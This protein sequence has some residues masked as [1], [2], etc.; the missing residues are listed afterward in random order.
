[1]SLIDNHKEAFIKAV[2]HFVTDIATLKTGR[3]NPAILDSISVDSYGAMS[4]INQVASVSVP[5]ARS[6]VIQPWDKG[7]LEGLEK[8]IRD[9][10]LGLSPVNEGDKIRI[11]IPQ[12]TEESRKDIVKTLHQKTEE[13]RIALRN[14]RDSV[15][16]EILEAEKNKEFG[17]DEKFTLMEELDKAVGS[18][19]T[20]IKDISDKKE[21]DIMKV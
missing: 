2:D 16:D 21:A 18:Y 13:A 19:N 12:M 17:E 4:P 8:A 10:D 5:D 1:M 3:A 20:Q 9:S 15:K 6:I 7:V 11:T 14:V